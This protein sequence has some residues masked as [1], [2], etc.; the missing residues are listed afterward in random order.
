MNKKPF[1]LGVAALLRVSAVLISGPV[2]AW[3]WCGSCSWSGGVVQRESVCPGSTEVRLSLHSAGITARSEFLLG[4]QAA[5]CPCCAQDHLNSARYCLLSNNETKDIQ[6][7]NVAFEKVGELS[8]WST[9]GLVRQQ[10]LT[11]SAGLDLSQV[12]EVNELPDP[13]NY[14]HSV[15]STVN[16]QILTQTAGQGCKK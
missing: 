16:S 5:R 2:T 11:E 4:T 10:C 15:V 9:C 14:V 3:W 6:K 8:S 12:T 1:L 13:S 7:V